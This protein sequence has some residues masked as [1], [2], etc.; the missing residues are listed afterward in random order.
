MGHL[1][2][3]LLRSP[4][5]TA[6][7]LAALAIGVGANTAIFSVINTVLLR[8][9]PYPVPDRLVGVWLRAPGFNLDHMDS[10]APAEYFTF[11]DEGRVFGKLG[12][13]VREAASVT[14]SGDP[15]EVV[16]GRRMVAG[17][18]LTWTDIGTA[19]C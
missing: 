14:G 11:R 18:D 8:P 7:T 13:W 6:I 4:G 9:L 3:R 10:A 1:V 19:C 2:R 5:F 15:E 12:L 16:V 17:P